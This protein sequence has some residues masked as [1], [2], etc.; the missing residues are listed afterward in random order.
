MTDNININRVRQSKTKSNANSLRK[1]RNYDTQIK[2]ISAL[3]ALISLLSIVALLTYSRDDQS[4]A[5]ISFFDLFKLFTGDPFIEA[6][7]ETTQNGLGLLGAYLSELTINGSIGFCIVLLP[8]FLIIYCYYLFVN[9]KPPQKLIKYSYL[10]LIFSVLLTSILGTFDLI[11]WLPSVGSEW[12]GSVGVFVSETFSRLIGTA[13]TLIVLIFAL[14]TT[15]IF[16]FGL[17]KNIASNYKRKHESQ[18][19]KEKSDGPSIKHTNEPINRNVIN[20]KDKVDENKNKKESSDDSDTQLD[21]ESEEIYSGNVKIDDPISLYGFQGLNLNIIKNE[22]E[23]AIESDRAELGNSSD[24]DEIKSDHSKEDPIEKAQETQERD[25]KEELIS[26]FNIDIGDDDET[27]EVFIKSAEDEKAIET[28]KNESSLNI[29]VNDNDDEDFDPDSPIHTIIH[30]KE[31]KYKMLPVELLENKTEPVSVSDEEL[32]TNG[33]IIQEKL[34]TFKIHI[35]NLSVTPGPVVTQYEFVPAAGIKISKIESLADDMAMALKAK[36]VRIIAPIPEKGTVGLEIPN[37]NPSLVSFA[38]SVYSSKFKSCDYHLPLALGKTISGDIFLT[39]LTKMPHLLIAGSTGSGKSVGIN[40]MISSLLYK[41]HPSQLKF[42]LIDPKKVELPQYGML[43][44]H[45]LAT[46]PDVK[47][48]IITKPEDAVTVLKAAVAEMEKRYDILAEVGQ[49]NI[50]DYNSKVR[51]GKFKDSTD[52]VHR[53]MPYI[54]V[55]V[56]ELADLML[57]ASKEIEEPITRLAQM[58]RAVGIHLIIATQRPSVD[59]ITGLIKA[60]F[61][62][63]IAYFVTSKIDSRTILDMQGAE[64]LLGRGDMLFMHAGQAKPIRIQNGFITTDEVEKICEY[65]GNQDGYSS[66]YMLPS[67]SEEGEGIGSI[68]KEDRDPLF[69]EAAKLIID[70]QQGSVS[71]IQRRLKV[72]Y[73]RAGR[74]IDEL[75]DAGVVGPFTGSKARDVLMESHSDLESIL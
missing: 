63:R 7:A 60:N 17:D 30:D 71:L 52:M 35:E 59:V 38:E 12:T 43:E 29:I 22:D 44:N 46:S 72:G 33:R 57:T 8:V 56:D 65:I 21:E 40:T 61:P 51:G 15:I 48:K 45:Y 25:N 54:V 9:R 27:D 39:D 64:K 1:K 24:S 50:A 26:N 4:N 19:A 20:L 49:R 23:K 73:A 55:V 67:L 10:Y 31:I 28:T 3:I 42:V 16:G 36:G 41:K 11:S 47:D 37:S 74:I 5:Q 75:E 69:A 13:G 62:A 53:E 6:K 34:E 2:I 32:K 58:A 18:I 68:S 66:P 14:S 70:Q